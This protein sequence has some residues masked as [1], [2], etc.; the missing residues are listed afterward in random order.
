M[1]FLRAYLIILNQ[2]GKLNVTVH[3]D[4]NSLLETWKREKEIDQNCAALVHV[5]FDRP[6]NEV[7]VELLADFPKRVLVTEAAR[8]ALPNDFQAHPISIGSCRCG[9]D[10]VDMSVYISIKGWGY[11]SSEHEIKLEL[12]QSISRTIPP[13]GWVK[14]LSEDF[15]DLYLVLAKYNIKNEIDFIELRN[16]LPNDYCNKIEN[17]RFNY[18]KNSSNNFDL[19]EISQR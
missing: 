11:I 16:T 17:R 8:W 6:A 2:R 7:I 18:F 19:Q 4:L 5:G 13:E 12:V 1:Q 9:A 14:Q 3:R 10:S 15:P